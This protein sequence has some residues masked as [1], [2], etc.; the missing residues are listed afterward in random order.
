MAFLVY[1]ILDPNDIWHWDAPY[2][3]VVTVF[4]L[5]SLI[6]FFLATTMVSGLASA[7]T[8]GA[9]PEDLIVGLYNILVLRTWYMQP[10]GLT[11]PLTNIQQVWASFQMNL[12]NVLLALWD[13]TFLFL[14]FLCAGIGIALFLQSLVRMDHKFVGGA[15]ISI[16]AIII[17]AAYRALIVPDL[18]PFPQDFMDFLISP[19]QILGLVSFAYL[20]VSYQMIY[21]SSVGKPVEDR[22]ETLKKQLLALRQ[23]TRK[24]DA[25]ER[26]EKV[27]TT[28]MSRSTG[29][30]AFSFLREAMERKVMGSQ[31]ALE[32]LDAVSDVR[33]LQIYV[34]ELLQSDPRARDELTAKAAAPSSAYVIGSTLTGSAIRF[35]TVVAVSFI[36]MSPYVVDMLLNLPIGIANSVEMI[37]PEIVVLFLVP[38]VGLFPFTAAVI[39]WMSKREVVEKE[40]LT[41]EEKEA[42]EKR[43]KD[44]ATKRKEAEKA[45]KAR[46]KARKKR[47][48]DEAGV[49]EWDKALEEAFKK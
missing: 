8:G 17:I 20:E 3:F 36:L 40:K 39:S 25:I 35:L 34:D 21:S 12:S 9:L 7:F 37:Q 15:F 27:S 16:Q 31:S 23:A 18:T 48:G 30:T 6:V 38:V 22:E 19:A 10:Y 43:K 41:K 45:R 28:G 33:R 46:T 4:R 29:A 26:G 13:N 47:K 32:S 2:T 42:A 44:L 24:Q 5:L 14:Y 49:D 1:D 11:D